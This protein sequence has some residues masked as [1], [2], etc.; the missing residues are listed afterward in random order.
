MSSA[1]RSGD[2]CS[3]VGRS[4][5]HRSV[6]RF[7]HPSFS[8]LSFVLILVVG[9]GFVGSCSD[10]TAPQSGY[11]SWREMESPTNENLNGVWGFDTGEAYAVGDNGTILYYDGSKWSPIETGATADLVGVWGFSPTEVVATG[12]SGTILFYDGSTWSR[13]ESG[14]TER[15][16]AVWGCPDRDL[17]SFYAFRAYAVGGGAPGSVIHMNRRGEWVSVQTGATEEFADIAGWG[18]ADEFETVHL[19]A[20]GKGGAAYVGSVHIMDSPDFD[21]EEWLAT[22]TGVTDDLAGIVGDAPNNVYVIGANGSVIQNTNQF[23]NAGPMAAWRTVGQL[24]GGLSAVAARNY[25]D[26]FIVGAN[27][28][29]VHFDREEFADMKTGTTVALNDVWS[30]ADVL[31]A[32]GDGG[33]ILRYDEPPKT[34]LCPFDMKLTATNSTSPRISWTPSCAVSKIV[35]EDENGFV[36]WF[37]AADGNLIEPGVQYGTAPEGTVELRPTGVPLAANELYTVSLIRRDWNRERKLGTWN[38]LPRADG[39]SEPV[40]LAPAA[41][42]ALVEDGYFY[43]VGLRRVSS[44]EIYEFADLRRIPARVWGTPQWRMLGDPVTREQELNVRWVG[45]EVLETDPE[46]G[47]LY[48]VAH[49]DIRAADPLPASGGDPVTVVWDHV[50]VERR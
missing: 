4:G 50:H 1:L 22:D 17:E 27:G 9:V 37:V 46:T 49:W 16:G 33:T 34:R 44:G 7:D 39:V 6:P 23:V 14:T 30:G 20:V 38:L 28:S 3:E 5:L 45:I 25:N 19:M 26:F 24:G 35:V 32:V 8:R 21:E 11:G 2:S 48:L 29:A 13:M 18:T 15:I 41:S 42:P 31:Y 40:A 12:E 43:F 47:Q 36:Q 10:T